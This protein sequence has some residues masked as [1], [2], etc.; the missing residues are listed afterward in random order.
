MAEAIKDQNRVPTMLGTSLTDG[1]TTLPIYANATDHSLVV[2]MVTAP[3]DLSGDVGER[4]QN[5]VV[6]FMAVSAV[7]GVTPVPIYAN[8]TG[9]KLLIQTT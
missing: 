3:A 9:N 6:V 7:D 4:D 8:A 5:R 2:D 1:V